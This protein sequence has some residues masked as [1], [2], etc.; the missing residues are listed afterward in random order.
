MLSCIVYFLHLCRRD[1][2]QPEYE[3]RLLKLKTQY[4]IQQDTRFLGVSTYLK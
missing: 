3:Y 2:K 4:T 1:T